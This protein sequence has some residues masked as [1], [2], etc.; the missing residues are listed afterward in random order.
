MSNILSCYIGG[1]LKYLGLGH[2]ASIS[3]LSHESNNSNSEYS[4]P[5]EA[6]QF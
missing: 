6:T 2:S 5:L 3:Y 1:F 4:E